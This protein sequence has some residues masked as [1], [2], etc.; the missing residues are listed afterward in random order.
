[1][2]GVIGAVAGFLVMLIVVVTG[3]ALL[4]TYFAIP[5]GGSPTPNYL[6]ANIV[7]SFLAAFGAG[8]VATAI[9]RPQTRIAIGIL[10]ALLLVSTLISLT[11]DRAQQPIWYLAVVAAVGIAGILLGARVQG[12]RYVRGPAAS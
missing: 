10:V 9:G 3:T 8:S 6:A 4:V 1:M 2:R 7:L 5:R 12:R 11:G